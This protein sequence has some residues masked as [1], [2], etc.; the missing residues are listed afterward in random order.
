MVDT[1]I[2]FSALL[3]SNGTIGD[4]LF[5]SDHFF[6]FYSPSY[7]RYEIEKHWVKLKKISKLSDENLLESKFLVFSKINLI[8]EE[9]IPIKIWHNAEKIV[10]K[11]DIDDI[12]FVALTA[13]LKA[14]L[15]TGDKVLY[16][17][18]KQNNFN[19]IYSTS[20]LISKRDY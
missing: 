19:R 2:I 13:F 1:N 8:N 18:L 5:N 9:I 10:E 15:W 4:L 11:I 6:E 14:Y 20:D 12:D 3:N 17:G 16:N 7:M